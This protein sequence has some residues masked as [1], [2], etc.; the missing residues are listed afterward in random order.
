MAVK[1]VKI[2]EMDAD[3]RSQCEN[4]SR[5]LRSL[6]PHPN[7]INYYDCFVKD[8]ELCLILELAQCGKCASNHQL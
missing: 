1:K 5:L 4:E 2:F 7:I 3:T 8:N 6:P